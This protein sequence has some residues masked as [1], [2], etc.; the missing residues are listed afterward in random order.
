MR[1]R[2]LPF[3]DSGFMLTGRFEYWEPISLSRRRT[4]VRRS[5][6]FLTAKEMT[7]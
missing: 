2:L 1:D 6:L 3:K 5:R 7:W 4:P